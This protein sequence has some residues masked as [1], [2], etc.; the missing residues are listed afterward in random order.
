MS[1]LSIGGTYS[2]RNSGFAM[3]SCMDG[4]VPPLFNWFIWLCAD[5]VR[6]EP[7]KGRKLLQLTMLATVGFDITLSNPPLAIICCAICII[8]G[9]FII[10]ARSGMPPAPPAP[11]APS[12]PPPP[13]FLNVS[14]N[15]PSPPAGAALGV[16]I[17]LAA[18]VG[19]ASEFRRPSCIA[20]LLGS[21]SR[22]RR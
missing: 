6:Q 14:A 17:S 5:K 22:P 11:P 20:A 18:S 15:P 3:S 7:L 16:A 4:R 1:L 12:A 8:A 9:L 19:W 13:K 21:N 2:D 10:L